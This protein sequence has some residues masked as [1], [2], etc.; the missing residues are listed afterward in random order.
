[1]KARD[2][3]LVPVA[4]TAWAAALWC[5]FVPQ[6]IV[7]VL[8]ICALAI[9]I[10]IFASV[11]NRWRGA[12]WGVVLVCL[13][14]VVGVALTV[15]WSA[16][17]RATDAQFD[18][19]VVDVEVTVSSSPSKGKDGRLWAD[20]E[21][22]AIGTPGSL[23]TRE[24]GAALPAGVPVRVG[25]QVTD[26][27]TMVFVPGA[28]V[29]LS[30]QVKQGDAGERAALVLF[31]QGE[32]TLVS[33]GS[34]V[35]QIAAAVRQAFVARSLAL[36]DPGSQLLPGLAVGDTRAVT[37]ELNQA[38]LASGLSH[39][40]AVSGS[41]CALVTAA[42]YGLVALLGGAR[43]VRILFAATTLVAF[44][45]LVTAEPSVVR[46]AAM[47]GLAMLSVLM[48]RPKA[49]L[50]MLLLAVTV[51]LIGDPWLAATPGFALSAAATAAL[52]VVAPPL[53]RGM[54]R[55]MPPLIALALAIPLA[56][57]IVCAPIIALFATEQSLI[58][59]VANLLAAPAAPIATVIGLLA[60]L[61]MPIPWLADMLAASAWLPSAWIATTAEVTA[62]LPAATVTV[63]AGIPTAIVVAAL[64][65][66]T[67]WLL[68]PA[69][70][71]RVSRVVTVLSAMIVSVVGGA[72]AGFA[73]L[74]GPV[75]VLTRPTEWSIAACDIG[76]GD[77]VLVRSAER[78][79][80]IDVGP[81]PEALETCLGALGVSHI[82]LLV[83][84]HFDLDH[85][86]GVAAVTGRVTTVM[87]SAVADRIDV[88]LL[89]DLQRA[90]AEMVQAQTG[91]RG[92]LGLSQ[93]RVLWPR[94]DERVFPIG[95]D[96]SV[97]LEFSGGGVPRS[98][99]LGDL[100]AESQRMLQRISPLR[101]PYDVVK[102]AHHGSADQDA[103]LYAKASPALALL[104]VGENCLLYTSPSP[105][106]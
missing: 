79:A 35:S 19:R 103:G 41:N 21:A 56:A 86:G 85:V 99:F 71:K 93:W 49:G 46:A 17:A 3:R 98:L 48:G 58:G 76:Q 10:S 82:D 60:C 38:M 92:E 34:A 67:G 100:G 91:M 88:A 8:A 70:G 1:M 101:G 69:G 24:S 80:L 33:K 64:S 62:A 45:V 65:G 59:V 51:L 26:E 55:W 54:Q 12:S 16:E 42:A 74:H 43:W 61:A 31:A 6:S 25:A 36:P 7:I 57:Q 73:L 37:Q 63:P 11:S 102:V 105:R 87:H 29:R 52:I 50:A 40:T 83:L 66:A 22:S 47:S 14:A 5:V 77:A 78:I 27:D 39:L 13:V 20:A 44:V 89:D 53:A 84:T 75:G 9:T 106:D 28:T 68:A 4:L 2:L 81:D 90:G 15:L 18:G 30:G 95:N 104:T 97:V 32:L 72:G 96:A 23:V 94:R